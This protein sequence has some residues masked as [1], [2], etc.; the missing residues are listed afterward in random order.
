MIAELRA[1][2]KSTAQYATSALARRRLRS[3]GSQLW[4]DVVPTSIR[5]QFWAQRDRIKLFTIAS[6]MDTVPWELLYPVDP[7]NDDGF[8]VEQFPVVRRVYGQDR[9][10]T[11]RLDKG[12][13]FIVPPKSPTN[14]LEEVAAVRAA[15]PRERA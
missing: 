10:R 13:G 2:S 7:G 8:L 6:D 5:E 4:G 12:A 14:A 3:L 15:L 9:A 11:L 1:M